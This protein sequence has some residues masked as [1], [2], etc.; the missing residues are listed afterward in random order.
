[1]RSPRA[2]PDRCLST[3]IG[4]VILARTLKGFQGGLRDRRTCFIC[5]TDGSQHFLNALKLSIRECGGNRVTGQNADKT[6]RIAAN[7]INRYRSRT[8]VGSGV[9]TV[10]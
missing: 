8:E 4:E 6:L 1:M 5:T 7:L 2:L 10:R 9:A 3:Q